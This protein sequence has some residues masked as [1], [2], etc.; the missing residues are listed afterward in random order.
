MNVQLQGI[1]ALITGGSGGMGFEMA[2]ALLTHG[3]AVVIAARPGDKLERAYAELRKLSPNAYAVPV[4]VRDERSVGEMA[5]WFKQTLPHLDLLVNNAGVGNNVT[6]DT[7]AIRFDELPLEAFR[8]VVETNFVGYYLVSRAMVPIMAEQ[9]R[10]KI[11]NISTSD[12]TMTMKGMLPYGPSRAA[13]DAMSRILAQELAPLGITVNILCPGGATD[14][15]MTTDAIRAA[16]GERL[17]PPTVLNEAILYLASPMSDGIT[18]VKITG[19]DFQT[20][21]PSQPGNSA[22]SGR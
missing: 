12:R 20:R 22:N 15:G 18:G 2:K 6:G 21:L 13:S 8:T 11:V 7:A 1:T 5:R 14:T 3:A 4:D 19:R 10:G 9:G 16:M 17:L